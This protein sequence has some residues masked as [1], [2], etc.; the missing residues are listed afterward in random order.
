MTA[1]HKH[2]AIRVREDGVVLKVLT[3]TVVRR[4]TDLKKVTNSVMVYRP[5][6]GRSGVYE[7]SLLGMLHGMFGLTLNT[8][9][10]KKRRR[11][12]WLSR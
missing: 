11:A 3:G 8:C 12:S 2:R 9:P 4:S 6:E 7:L 1:G 5:V 10:D